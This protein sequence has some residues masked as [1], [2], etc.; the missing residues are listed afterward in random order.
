MSELIWYLS[1]SIL[2]ILEREKGSK[3]ETSMWERNQRWT[4]TWVCALGRD[5]TRDLLVHRTTLNQL[6][7]PAR[8]CVGLWLQRGDSPNSHVV[9]GSISHVK[10]LEQSLAHSNYSANVTSYYYINKAPS[11]W[12]IVGLFF[13]S[14]ELQ[15]CKEVLLLFIHYLLTEWICWWERWW[16]ALLPALVA[17]VVSGYE[18]ASG[19]WI[20]GLELLALSSLDCSACPDPEERAEEPCLTIRFWNTWASACREQGVGTSSV[21]RETCFDF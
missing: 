17:H 1:F 3:R 12:Y 16:G 9:Q 4:H 5:R 18:L 2:L 8:A 7:R 20:W 11:G 10:N 6:S 21:V 14:K 15:I 13:L 19:G